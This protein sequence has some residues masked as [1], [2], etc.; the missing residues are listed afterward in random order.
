MVQAVKSAIAKRFDLIYPY[1]R[2]PDD[3]FV[4]LSVA[5]ALVRFPEIAARLRRDLELALQ[6]ETDEYVRDMIGAVI[7]GK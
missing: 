1:L 4:R 7:A 5:E 2:C 3:F 6:F